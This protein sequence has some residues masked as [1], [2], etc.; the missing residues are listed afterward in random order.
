MAKIDIFKKCIKNGQ[1]FNYKSKEYR[2]V[3]GCK[4]YD[5]SKDKLI[6][7][8]D[9]EVNYEEVV[10]QEPDS[11]FGIVIG[12][13]DD[14]NGKP[15]PDIF[16]CVSDKTNTNQYVVIRQNIYNDSSLKSMTFH[17]GMA[18]C[19]DGDIT[20]SPSNVIL[21]GFKS[22][23]RDDC[24]GYGLY[25]YIEDNTESILKCIPVRFKSVA[26]FALNE[27]KQYYVDKKIL[28]EGIAESLEGL[29][30]DYNFDELYKRSYNIHYFDEVIDKNKYND[31]GS[32]YVSNKTYKNLVN[33]LGRKIKNVSII[34]YQRDIDLNIEE[35]KNIN[36][37]VVYDK[38]GKIYLIM[39][40]DIN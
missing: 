32:I 1:K 26:R 17:M 20:N 3:Q 13:I 6:N 31:D 14:I 8:E 7:V 21:S 18:W 36:H 29:M 28:V 9:F 5:Y 4:I 19:N 16:I 12:L 24:K 39:F 10:I 27:M 35:L 25:T 22:F 33:M 11:I 15:I 40:D 34:Q 38:S 23:Y 37:I 30:V 2:F